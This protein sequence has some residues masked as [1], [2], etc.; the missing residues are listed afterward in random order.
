MLKKSSAFWPILLLIL[1]IAL[2]ALAFYLFKPTVLEPNDFAKLVSNFDECAALGNP[3][4][5]SYPAQCLTPDGR[6]FV[7]DIG[8]ELEKMDLIKI[9]SPRPNQ[10]V[11][12]PL[13]IEGFARGYWFFEADF[14]VKLYDADNNLIASGIAQAQGEWMTEDFVPFV[15]NL[16]FEKPLTEKGNLILEKDNPSGLPEHDDYL[17]VPLFFKD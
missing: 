8:N 7:Q 10:V 15:A 3:I 2:I 12:S 9:N 4:L 17:R 11:S 5:E 13:R 14:P 6:T 1:L 16:E